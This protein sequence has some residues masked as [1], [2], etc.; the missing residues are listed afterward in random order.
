MVGGRL[1]Q[2]FKDGLLDRL[3]V[4]LPGGLFLTR[5]QRSVP[6]I[7]ECQVFL[8]IPRKPRTIPQLGPPRLARTTMDPLRSDKRPP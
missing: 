6:A 7:L 2:E 5:E 8:S 3:V 1:V 4:E